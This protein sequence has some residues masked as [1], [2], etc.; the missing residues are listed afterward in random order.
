MFYLCSFYDFH[1]KKSGLRDLRTSKT[2]EASISVALTRDVKLFER[3]APSTYCV[4]APY[5]KDPADGEAILAE[6]RKKIKAFEN[7]LAGPEDVND[8]E[9]DEDFECDI[10]EDPEVDDLATLPSASKSADLGEANGLSG[11]GGEIMFSDVKANVKSEVEKEVSSPP[12]SSMKTIV[13][14]CHSEQGKDAAVSCMDNKNAVVEDIKQGKS[15]VLGLT[16]GDYCHLSVQERLE[17]LVALVGI[18]NEGNSIRASL[19]VKSGFH[20]ISF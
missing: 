11:K 13:P 5:V 12:T 16:E 18:A 17:A 9:K 10:D 20:F 19:E 7:G 2:P 8:L 15:W 4:R 14:Q 3:I 6:A 1:L